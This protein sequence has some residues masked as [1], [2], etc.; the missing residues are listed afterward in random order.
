M[1]QT[2][3]VSQQPHPSRAERQRRPLHSGSKTVY[4]ACVGVL[5]GLPSITFP[6]WEFT[7]DGLATI[8]KRQRALVFDPPADYDCRIDVAHIAFELGAL[9]GVFAVGAGVV[10]VLRSMRRRALE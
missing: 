3:S 10:L 6:V 5:L 1:G 2:R 9:Y 7:T 8:V 4:A